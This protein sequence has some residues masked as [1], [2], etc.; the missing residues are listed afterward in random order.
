[1]KFVLILI[2][3]VFP[4]FALAGEKEEE[5]YDILNKYCMVASDQPGTMTTLLRA[6]D[7]RKLG[8]DEALAKYGATVDVW[9][10]TTKSSEYAIFSL[11]PGT[12]G[13]RHNNLDFVQ[14][15]ER[16][17][18][19]LKRKAKLQENDDFSVSTF[20]VTLKRRMKKELIVSRN[21]VLEISTSKM[22]ANKNTTSL[23]VISS[24]LYKILVKDVKTH[25]QCPAK[26]RGRATCG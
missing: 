24:P 14:I 4:L 5:A 23:V 2:M 1:M 9:I 6:N 10:V 8:K 22:L 16:A 21:V 18:N 25:A 26:D 7:A 13:V 20:R 19:K 15:T 17:R 11:G 3:S 12:C